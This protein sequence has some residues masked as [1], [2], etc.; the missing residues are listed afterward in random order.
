MADG[1]IACSRLDTRQAS[2]GAEAAD[3]VVWWE[4]G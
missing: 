3:L 1:Q 2:L 4:K